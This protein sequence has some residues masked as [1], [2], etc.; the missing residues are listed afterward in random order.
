M[1][2]SERA[3][4]SRNPWRLAAL[5]LALP[6]AGCFQPLYGEAAHPG[7]TAEMRAIAVAPIKDRIGHYLGNDLITN[8]NGTGSNPEPKYRLTVT[9]SMATGTPTV[10]SQLQVANAA[11]VTGTANYTLTPAGGGDA[12]L[13]GTAS[14]VV[15]YDRTD[16][17][18]SD[19]RAQR[20]TEIRLAKSLAEE[21]ELR[22]AAFL[23][24]KN[25]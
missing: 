1:S 11:T 6:A 14:S 4:S 25:K 15:V 10:T 17:L 19:L 22:I 18:F 13:T 24:E 7:L 5:L 12:L 23:S 20:D 9:T 2:L 16:Q 3:P 21:I 8:L